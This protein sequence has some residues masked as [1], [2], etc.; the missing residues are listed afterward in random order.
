[1][2]RGDLVDD[3]IEEDLGVEIFGGWRGILLDVAWIVV[4]WAIPL[5]RLK[6]EGVLYHTWIKVVDK[7]MGNDIV[8]NDETVLMQGADGNLEVLWSETRVC[9]F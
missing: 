1:M 5:A 2:S 6:D 4:V 3:G 9:E 8:D 7:I